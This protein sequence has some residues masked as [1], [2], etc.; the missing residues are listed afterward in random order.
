MYA[1][2]KLV[3]DGGLALQ[4][5]DHT[6]WQDGVKTNLKGFLVEFDSSKER[7]NEDIE[8]GLLVFAGGWRR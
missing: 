3:N 8:F 1:V 7:D 4:R 2:V 6:D 5:R